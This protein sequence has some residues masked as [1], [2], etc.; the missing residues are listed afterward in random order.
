MNNSVKKT[1]AALLCCTVVAGGAGAGVL[2]VNSGED[3]VV[4]SENKEAAANADENSVPEKDETVYVLAGADGSVS[5]IIV[6]DWIKN[7]LGEE[8]L[9]DKTELSDV[10]NV[11]GNET[12]T[13]N[14][15]NMRV[16]DAA[17]NDIYYQG[18]IE[19]E[20][21]VQLSVSYTL[22][23]KSVSPSELAGKS[24]KVTI[25]FDYKNNQYE[26]VKIDGQDEKIYVPFAMLTGV[27]LD[28]DVFTNV[29]LSNGKLINDG[30]RTIVAG[31]A[32]PGLQENLKLDREK[33]EIPDY[34]EIRADVKNFSMTNTV[35]VATNEIFN[36]I[37][38]NKFDGADELT[39]SLNKMK[40]AMDQLLDGSSQLYNGL[41]TLAD[42]SGELISGINTLA[43]GAEKLKGGTAEVKKG[44]AELASGAEKLADGLGTL[45]EN[46][47]TL[48]AGSKQVFDS[49][50]KTATAQLGAAG[51]TVPD[52]TIENYAT[53]LN[54][55]IASLD[56]EKVAETARATALEKVT[57]AVNAQ[58]DTVRAAVKAEVEKQVTIKVTAAT[59]AG[60][61]TKVLEAMGMTDETYAAGVAAGV[62]TEQQQAAVKAAVDAQMETEAVK[63]MTE[64]TVASQMQT[65]EVTATVEAKTEEQ[66]GLLIEQNMN[67]PEVQG[68]ITAALEKAK[69]GAASV[70]ALKEQ[71]DSY[72]TFYTGLNRYTE[73][74]ATAKTG[75]DALSGGANKLN[76]GA[77]EL[78]S[79]MAQLYDGIIT[80]KNGAPALSDGVAALKDGAMKLSDG[81]KQ[82]NEEGIKKITDAVDGDLGSLVARIRATADV[83]K[84]YK[85]FAGISDNMDGQT[86][87]IYRTDNIKAK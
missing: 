61:Q 63:A 67:S 37:D 26:T 35:T 84:N 8:K 57:A 72:N 62:V 23:G 39:E 33:L 87:F 31:V 34:V 66:I 53:V 76:A 60:V 9:N 1:L 64:A 40:D 68:Q 45:C 81:L 48:N 13:M 28:N 59:R 65:A 29:E 12:Y 74:V 44:T 41:S 30:D 43:Q 19:K 86:K 79:G 56:T 58:K 85:S 10:E 42:K 55:V 77:A 78:D 5:K 73:G 46:N 69:S 21:P 80:L 83:S 16:W 15:D 49:L 17:G 3:S 14:G 70:S 2:A 20:L 22:D 32:F 24:G 36:E 50:L 7:T 47:E 27:I 54:G 82:F 4:L 11:K 18:N 6:S 75:A 25:R 71:L 52:L 51:L 38:T